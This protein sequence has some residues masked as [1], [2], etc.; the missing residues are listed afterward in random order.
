M[1]SRLKKG[2][3]H[4]KAAP[5][6]EGCDGQNFR[7][8]R[9]RCWCYKGTMTDEARAR[10]TGSR[11][12]VEE[13]A[14]GPT[15]LTG[16]C[17]KCNALGPSNYPPPTNLP[18]ARLPAGAI[19]VQYCV[20]STSRAAVFFAP[21]WPLPLP[22]SAWA[23]LGLAFPEELE[24]QRLLLPRGSASPY[25]PPVGTA[26]WGRRRWRWRWKEGGWDEM[27]GRG[28]DAALGNATAGPEGRG[29]GFPSSLASRSILDFSICPHAGP[30]GP[31]FQH[32]GSSIH[33]F[34]PLWAAY[35]LPP[36]SL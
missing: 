25:F 12:T 16:S 4:R 15:Q 24:W 33:Q 36:W 34:W 19:A 22:L 5:S 32:P 1:M 10:G 23:P 26:N 6:P 2:R 29:R 8:A 3:H 14:A 21:G 7:G 17:C 27:G 13:W 20:A 18:Q 30:S 9:G 35:C 11:G 31:G 28:V